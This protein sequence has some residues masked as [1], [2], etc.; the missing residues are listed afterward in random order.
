MA[1]GRPLR[2]PPGSR[3]DRRGSSSWNHLDRTR[4]RPFLCIPEHPR[5]NWCVLTRLPCNSSRSHPDKGSSSKSSSSIQID[6]DNRMIRCF[7]CTY[8][9]TALRISARLPRNDSSN[10]S[11]SLY[12]TICSSNSRQG[13]SGLTP[14]LDRWELVGTECGAG[15]V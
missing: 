4:N 15:V 14:P 9:R 11:L 10:H 7:Q 3:L 5:R 12:S 8:L 2:K 1:A 6:L 13:V